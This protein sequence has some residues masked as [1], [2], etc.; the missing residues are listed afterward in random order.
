MGCTACSK[1]TG[2]DDERQCCV[3]KEKGGGK[4]AW[5]DGDISDLAGERLSV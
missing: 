4:I 2:E 1:Y 3:G 5:E